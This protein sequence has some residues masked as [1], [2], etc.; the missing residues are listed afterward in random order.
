MDNDR[1]V[2]IA[3]AHLLFNQDKI[4][5]TVKRGAQNYELN[6]SPKPGTALLF[7]IAE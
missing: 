7:Y 6:I 4:F 2:I 5:E 1:F 3:S